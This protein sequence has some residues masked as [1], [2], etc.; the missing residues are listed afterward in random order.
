[1]YMDF[2]GMDNV[3]EALRQSNRVH[4]VVLYLAEW[5]LEKVLAVMQ[6][7]FPDRVDKP[8]TMVKR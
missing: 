8:A 1:M 7:P 4:E 3:I 2:S 6:A 5:Q